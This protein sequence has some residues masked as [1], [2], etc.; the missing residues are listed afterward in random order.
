MY[1]TPLRKPLHKEYSKRPSMHNFQLECL[2]ENKKNWPATTGAATLRDGRAKRV[3]RFH[4]F[5]ERIYKKPFYIEWDEMANH[6]ETSHTTNARH[7]FVHTEFSNEKFTVTLQIRN[8]ICLLFLP[9]FLRNNIAPMLSNICVEFNTQ[10]Q[11][12]KHYDE[13]G[14]SRFEWQ[15]IQS[16]MKFHKSKIK[17]QNTALT[18]YHDSLAEIVHI[19]DCSSIIIWFPKMKIFNSECPIWSLWKLTS[20][21]TLDAGNC[22]NY[23]TVLNGSHEICKCWLFVRRE[24]HISFLSCWS[25][26]QN[27]EPN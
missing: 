20:L 10:C 18:E 23:I 17:T 27:H 7:A 14:I 11:C 22:S 26:I 3:K 21:K 9:L 15:K 1:A 8:I 4:L 12:G 25:G 19:C 2:R 6:V 5:F 13:R 24:S 16:K